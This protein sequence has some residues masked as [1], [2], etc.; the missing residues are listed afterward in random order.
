[1]SNEN[2]RT[3]RGPVIIET[4]LDITASPDIAPP[5]PE[6]E[7][8][9]MQ[10]VTAIAARRGG[11]LGKVFWSAVSGLLGM[12]VSVAVWDFATG[13]LARNAVLG[14]AA[15]VLLG[16][17]AVALVVL[18]LREAAAFARLSK[19]DALRTAVQAAATSDARQQAL[20]VMH[21]LERLYS[22]REELRWARKSLA[23]VSADVLDAPDIVSLAERH[24]MA[25]LDAAAVAEISS[26]ARNV[27]GATALI[28][29]AFADVAVALAANVRMVRRIAEVYGG[30]AGTFGSWRLLRAV[31]THL[32]ATGVVS[33]GDDLIGSVAGGGALS[34]I[35]RRFGE[36]VING[37]LTA[38]VGV[39]AMEVCRPMPFDTLKRPSV[40][41][42]VKTAL[43]GMFSRS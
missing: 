9:A 16:L 2:T 22:A 8:R 41:G 19:I 1:V 24:L 20:D 10:Q 40:S 35:S 34:K 7:G 12:M 43:S 26:A 17:A 21:R 25:P 3:R 11:W 28:P 14:Q 31:S 23:E 13:L 42:I 18:V 5:V 27:A 37:A 30:R 32:L 4:G 39:A 33:V 36:G 15:L 29:L 38:R 6:P